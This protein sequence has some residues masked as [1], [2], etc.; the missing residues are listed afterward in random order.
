MRTHLK[1]MTACLL[2][3]LICFSVFAGCKKNPDG[4]SSTTSTGTSSVE[5]VEVP[6]EPVIDT[7]TGEIKVAL[8]NTVHDL[9]ADLEDNGSI[10]ADQTM[11][12][13]EADGV[14]E[15]T[16]DTSMLVDGW[17]AVVYDQDGNEVSRYTIRVIAP[18]TPVNSDTATGSTGTGTTTSTGG[19]NSTPGSSGS[20]ST[21]PGPAVDISDISIPDESSWIPEGTITIAEDQNNA[22]LTAA[23]VDYMALHPNVKINVVQTAGG[24]TTLEQLKT[25]LAGG[26]AADIVNMDSCYITTA[27]AANQLFDLTAFG[28][29]DIKGLFTASCWNAVSSSTGDQVFGLPFDANTIC[30][31]Y[32]VDLFNA[33]GVTNPPSTFA[34]MKTAASSLLA[35][36]PNFAP[37][38]FPFDW[39][40]ANWKAFMYFTW[41]WRCGGEILT[42]DYKQA[43]F[44]STVGVEAL[45]MIVD[46]KKDKLTTANYQHDQFFRGEVGMI[47]I[48]SWTYESTF[49]S[50]LTSHFGASLM[51]ELKA[52]VPRYSG[53]GLYSYCLPN[54]ITKNMTDEERA[55]ALNTARVAY[56]F[57][58]FLC[59]SQTY[60]LQYCKENNFI[61]SL[62]SGQ[63]DPFYDNGAWP[64]Y[65]EQL[66]LAKTRP[67]VNDWNRIEEYISDAIT[68][69][70]S[71]QRTVKEALDSAATYTNKR[72]SRD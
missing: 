33:A 30:L 62:I 51:P 18:N 16:D 23:I 47:D 26:S 65:V 6:S 28:A 72:L 71:E 56:D 69:A 60:Q 1:R 24:K 22:T 54:K 43:A 31:L 20:T 45:Q 10:T 48:G 2:A 4:T 44:N 41:L 8:G 15:V 11:K 27:G 3:V 66:P 12:V 19:S 29:N 35:K 49:E 46:L 9:I 17:I 21:P 42:S 5:Y 40:V 34:E 52:G 50:G 36:Y 13:F 39:P 58:Q 32:N 14:T 67:G 70:V 25:M 64:V 63:S 61:T 7:A 57:I 55:V 38:T 68:L 59:T 53:L 37:Y